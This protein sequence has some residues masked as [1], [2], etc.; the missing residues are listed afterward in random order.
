MPAIEAMA[1]RD[2]RMAGRAYFVRRFVRGERRR[3]LDA[4]LQRLAT[5]PAA[6]D[7]AVGVEAQVALGELAVEGAIADPDA[8]VR[9]AAAMGAAAHLDV[10]TS[11][12]LV[13]RAAVE[14]DPSAREAMATGLARVD[15]GTAL[16]TSRLV[17]RLSAGGADAALASL[18]LA[19]RT[20]G[21]VGP[22]PGTL[23]AS[24]DPLLRS[25]AARG[26]GAS[27][28]PEAEGLLAAAYTFEAE[29]AVRRAII[30]ALASRGLPLGP[31]GEAS[32]ALAA[33]LDPDRST[34]SIAARALRGEP[35]GRS[36]HVPEVA[37]V[38]LVA[39]EG[40]ALPA[41]AT[42]TVVDADGFAWPLVFDED[43]VALGPGVAPG[44]F[45]LHLAPRLPPYI[46]GSP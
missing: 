46:A 42:A 8:R 32:L 43:G 23:L 38:T 45:R 1:Q 33:Q 16:P 30:G 26:L 24:H 3:T 40:S 28:A 29:P 41:G 37:W 18:A 22:E 5:S 11:E 25:H 44:P 9:A 35:P 19:R 7:R 6:A 12:A 4:L 10:R 27:K 21:P 31:W 17:D 20:P 14:P 34:R 13:T 39:A 36:A 15:A 2:A